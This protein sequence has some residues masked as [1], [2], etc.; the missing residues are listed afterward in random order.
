[1]GFQ[2]P[3]NIRIIRV[4][5]TGKVEV[6]HILKAFEAGAE[7]VVVIG[8]KFGEC[9]FKEGNFRAAKKVERVQ[10]LIEEVGLEGERVKFDFVP[11]PGAK[12]FAAILSDMTEKV[13]SMGPNPLGQ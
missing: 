5:C 7:G 12:K 6:L 10:S 9:Y 11:G 4:L 3:S 8:C 13:K 2:I 1:M